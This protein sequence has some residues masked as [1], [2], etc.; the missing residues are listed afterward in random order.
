VGNGFLPRAGQQRWIMRA[1]IGIKLTKSEDR[2]LCLW[3]GHILM[4]EKLLT[5]DYRFIGPVE[6]P[7]RGRRR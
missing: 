4:V 3:D 1:A 7:N 2:F 6:Q 5:L